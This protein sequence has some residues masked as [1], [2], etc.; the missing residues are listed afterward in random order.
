[1]SVY[2][3]LCHELSVILKIPI[4][5]V[6][7]EC[8]FKN[9]CYLTQHVLDNSEEKPNF[10]RET[11]YKFEYWAG[12]VPEIQE[13]CNCYTP[14]RYNF[15]CVFRETN[16]PFILGSKCIK[17]LDPRAFMSKCLDINCNK[18][19][20]S[21]Y[22]SLHKRKCPCGIFHKNN[23]ICYCYVCNK[24]VKIEH[25]SDRCNRCAFDKYY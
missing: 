15:V 12:D 14:I 4:E 23:S 17:R 19:I 10:N 24:K 21:G 11:D 20:E 8:F 5:R 22:C 16:I 13:R 3:T 9:E 2:D 18:L 6:R 7:G 25:G 1:M